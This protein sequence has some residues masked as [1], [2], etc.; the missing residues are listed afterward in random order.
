[1]LPMNIDSLKGIF[2]N[3]IAT[4]AVISP[5]WL[6]WLQKVSTFAAM[7]MPIMGVIW[8]GTQIYHAWVN[9]KSK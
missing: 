5:I 8:L 3:S 1:M 6:P 9:K 7:V 2:S 4:L